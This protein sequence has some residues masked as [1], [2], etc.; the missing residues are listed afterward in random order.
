MLVAS[1]FFN[2]GLID[3]HF[4]ESGNHESVGA[5]LRHLIMEE[6]L[7]SDVIFKS[8]R[9]ILIGSDFSLYLMTILTYLQ[10][11]E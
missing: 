5:S 6:L 9:L 8:F 1:P 2:T 4:K 7:I 3:A 11:Q 10:N